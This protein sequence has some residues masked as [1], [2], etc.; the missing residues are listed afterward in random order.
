MLVQNKAWN[1]L[2]DQ[3]NIIPVQPKWRKK[4]K[5]SAKK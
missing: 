4:V 3:K 5:T 1:I 2:E